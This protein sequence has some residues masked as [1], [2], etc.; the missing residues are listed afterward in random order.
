MS[1][2]YLCGDF[3]YFFKHVYIFQTVSVFGP[4]R[5][6]GPYYAYTHMVFY[7]LDRMSM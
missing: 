7:E 6:S 5:T 2:N 1:T 3:L 4:D